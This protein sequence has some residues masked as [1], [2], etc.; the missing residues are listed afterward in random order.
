MAP[1]LASGNG[2]MQIRHDGKHGNDG[3]PSP[4]PAKCAI[5]DNSK[6]VRPMQNRNDA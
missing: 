5:I 2:V 4:V 1:I 3:I 6:A